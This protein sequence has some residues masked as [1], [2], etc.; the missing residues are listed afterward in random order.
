MCLL[1]QL[2]RINNTCRAAMAVSVL[3]CSV[4]GAAQLNVGQGRNGAWWWLGMGH[5]GDRC[6]NS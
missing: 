4:R 3:S 1:S 6:R 5:S 2:L